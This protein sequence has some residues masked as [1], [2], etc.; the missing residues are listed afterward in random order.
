MSERDESGRSPEQPMS[1]RQRRP[2]CSSCSAGVDEDTILAPL[3]VL[4][5]ERSGAGSV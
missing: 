2:R 3:L 1:R 4:N 5:L